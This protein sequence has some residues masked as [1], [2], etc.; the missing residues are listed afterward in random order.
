MT[1][2][3]EFP[4]C[5]TCGNR[6]Y[7]RAGK[8]CEFKDEG[9]PVFVCMGCSCHWHDRTVKPNLCIGCGCSEIKEYKSLREFFEEMLLD[10]T[11]KDW[12][13]SMMEC[14]NALGTYTDLIEKTR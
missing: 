13:L 10:P 11:N 9:K 3:L 4:I 5:D 8:L 12:V 2:K 6:H 14:N 1:T 7:R